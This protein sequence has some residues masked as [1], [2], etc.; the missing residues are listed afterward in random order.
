MK[1]HYFL[2]L[3]LFFTHSIIY[4]QTLWEDNFESYT[5]G[6]FLGENGWIREG[7]IDDWVQI[8]NIDAEH[9]KSIQL[10]TDNANTS[11]IFVTHYN[12][13]AGREVNNDVLEI[14]FE[15]YTGQQVTEGLGQIVIATDNFEEIFSIIMPSENNSI[16]L[17]AE[18]MDEA[19]VENRSPNTWYHFTITYN[20]VTGE[21]MAQTNNQH[22]IT[23]FGSTGLEPN[24]FDFTSI[25]ESN[26]G[27]DNI[28]VA[29]TN[30]SILSASDFVKKTNATN[31]FP[32]PA[33]SSI[34]LH[35]NKK[36]TQSVLF[37]LTG[38]KIKEFHNLNQLDLSNLGSGSYLLKILFAEGVTETH[39]IVKK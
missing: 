28:S 1:K 3:A 8:V 26:L 38:R 11:G 6:D 37:D 21:I 33:T 25:I 39:K 24:V 12:D 15:L 4:S 10:N 31:I 22:V 32:N 7:G 14:N 20:S 27:I 35:T 9:G 23:G 5:L 29:A 16:V 2:L 18:N 17:F 19:L 30:E 13:W 34:N 36:I